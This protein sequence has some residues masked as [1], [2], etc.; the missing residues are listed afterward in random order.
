MAS[1]R[2]NS[3]GHL[4]VEVQRPG[5]G[6]LVQ[7]DSS[8]AVHVN[9]QHLPATTMRQQWQPTMPASLSAVGNDSRLWVVPPFNEM[10]VNSTRERWKSGLTFKWDKF[11]LIGASA[12]LYRQCLSGLVNSNN[13]LTWNKII[14]YICL[15]ILAV[16][17]CVGFWR[18]RSHSTEE[19]GAWGWDIDRQGWRDAE[20][21]WCAFDR[22]CQCVDSEPA[23]SDA[24]SEWF[25]NA[26]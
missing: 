1:C 8:S 13:K 14:R 16:H 6:E 26:T 15:C 17:R 23:Y 18:G 2:L 5:H 12:L 22:F 9:C 11:L 7:F 4:I 20:A 21:V 25:S 24:G 10:G 19:V 3:G